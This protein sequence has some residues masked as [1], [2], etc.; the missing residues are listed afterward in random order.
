MGQ[1][2]K[3]T[4]AEFLDDKMYKAPYELMASV[5][6]KKDKAIDDTIGQYQGYLDKLK[7]D[8]L[9]QDSPELRATIQQYQTRIDNA[10][11][12]ISSDPMNYQKYTPDLNTLGRDITNTWSSTGKVGTM[13]ANKKKVLAEYETLDKLAK[14]K[15]YTGDYIAAEKR[16]ILAKYQGVQWDA[17]RGKAMGAPEIAEA[18]QKLDFD[19]GFLTH[20]KAQKISRTKDTPGGPWVYRHEGSSEVLSPNDI[21][22]AYMLQANADPNTQAALKR[23]N[24]LGVAGYESV[25]LNEV[26]T[27]VPVKDATGKVVM[28]NG[29][30]KMQEVLNPNNYWAKK[31]GAAGETF[32][33]NNS[34]TKDTLSNNEGYWKEWQ[35]GNELEDKAK[36][37]ITAETT[38]VA[39]IETRDSTVDQLAENNTNAS[40]RVYNNVQQALK[41][42]TQLGIK[43]GTKAYD[44][45]KNGNFTALRVAGK[46]KEGFSG[47]VD[48]LEK[49]YKRAAAEKKLSNSSV[50]A[51]TNSLP[52]D[53]QKIMYT[54]KWR[55]DPKIVAAYKAYTEKAHASGSFNAVTQENQVT[56]MNGMDMDKNTKES[57]K[58][59]INDDLD[60]FRFK[61]GGAQGDE[62]IM[63]T[64]SGVKIAFT[65]NK[66]L[67]GK[68]GSRNGQSVTYA[69]NPTGD[70]S[71]AELQKIGIVSM[72][73]T[74][75]KK[76]STGTKKKY[77]YYEN[78]KQVGMDVAEDTFGVVK[79]YDNKGQANMGV[80]IQMGKNTIRATIGSSQVTN[81]QVREYFAKNDDDLY[82]QNQ[83][84]KT[85]WKMITQESKDKAGNV[86]K[87]DKGKAY[88]NGV[89]YTDS[90]GIL[91]IKK[92]VM[93]L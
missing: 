30:P 39:Y 60:K 85:N 92:V 3:G 59:V 44:Q 14:E 81:P 52:A 46:N 21:M 9:E 56:S 34:D 77:F 25:G 54:T 15:G 79:A 29:Q 23:Y 26:Y 73:V 69:Y 17:E 66:A 22:G 32:K 70:H 43:P 90:A 48:Q 49:E 20:L 27:K 13:E 78:G 24:Q 31:M 53:L 28:E 93:G 4:P 91:A 35:R 88:Y 12:G 76:S 87:M 40:T 86:Y 36:E 33:V 2:Y 64:A 89:Q 19:E 74:E 84:S 57:F 83:D 16:N 45:I 38:D 18:Y 55:T 63:E 10:V 62:E 37:N 42:A 82:F 1:F 67:D 8:V 75:D 47:T 41:E 65:T 5:I 58:K 6:D 68:V 71:L 61:L 80:H 51:F 50:Q 7:A 72:A 11:Q